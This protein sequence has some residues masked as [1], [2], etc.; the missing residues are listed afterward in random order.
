MKK[1]ILTACVLTLLG[2]VSCRTHDD[3]ITPEDTANLEVMENS[4]VA[5]DS[6]TTKTTLLDGDPIPPPRR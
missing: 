2:T 3:M 4:A 1:V 6:A 5:R